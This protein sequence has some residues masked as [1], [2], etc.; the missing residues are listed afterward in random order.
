MC[1]AGMIAKK[2]VF[3]TDIIVSRAFN[4]NWQKFA[5][6]QKVLKIHANGYNKKIIMFKNR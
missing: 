5:N 2:S 1:R 4:R 6:L 3:A